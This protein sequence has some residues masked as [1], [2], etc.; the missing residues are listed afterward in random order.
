MTFLNKI[1]QLAD[2]SKGIKFSHASI[3]L[4]NILW[5]LV[6]YMTRDCHFWCK[7]AVVI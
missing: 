1:V 3:N 6:P 2:Y 5:V 4:N 7:A